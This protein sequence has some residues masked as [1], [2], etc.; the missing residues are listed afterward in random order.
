MND[1]KLVC[2]VSVTRDPFHL[3]DCLYLSKSLSGLIHTLAYSIAT[4]P[5]PVKFPQLLSLQF[6]LVF[7]TGAFSPSFRRIALPCLTYP[8]NACHAIY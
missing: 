3:F 6:E 2:R 4:Y 7:H 8:L 1:P 5:T